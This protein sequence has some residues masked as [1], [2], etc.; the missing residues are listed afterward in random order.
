[1]DL[2]RAAQLF[3]LRDLR[4]ALLGIFVVGGGLTL[5][6]LTLYAQQ[7]GHVPLIVVAAS[8]SLGFVL[9]ILLF[10]VPPLAR[11]AGR[12][13]SQMNL[14]FEFAAG[15]A[16]AIGLL[17]IVGFSA[18]STGNNLLFLVLAF[19]LASLL[20]AFTAGSICL[21]RLDVTMRF[22]ETIF[23]EEKTPILV[24]MHNRKRIFPAFSV[25][26]EVRGKERERSIAAEHMDAVFPRW[27][28][29]RL[30]QAPVIRRTLSHFVYT[31]ARSFAEN[32]ADHRF[33][34]R[35]KLAI[36]DFEL[37]TRFPFGFFRHR[38]RLPAREAELIVFPKLVEVS[39]LLD[40]IALDAGRRVAAKKGSGHDL[41]ALRDYLPE[42][43]LRRVDWKATARTRRLTVRE[44]AADDER[45]VAV[46]LDL[47]VSDDGEP[48]VREK[49]ASEQRGESVVVS[50]RF[51]A[52]ASIACSLL[53]SLA[54]ERSELRLVVGDVDTGFGSGR[55][56]LHE[57]LKQISLASPEPYLDQLSEPS[58]NLERILD[59][60]GDS[61]CLFVTSSGVDGLSPELLQKLKIIGF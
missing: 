11:N 53:M 2:K 48:P 26:V 36:K 33:P 24:T 58:A 60:L 28:A 20:V 61:H 10:I 17:L 50:K 12:E 6:G 27:I 31:R 56:H 3:S 46:I 44:F 16:V 9:L 19:L 45:R 59:R 23:A 55:A 29:R 8:A 49:V 21:R 37:S 1:M 51:E 35:G 25:V 15:G 18:W 52:G 5:S 22:P 40:T 32:R 34:H 39:A 14:P 7:I 47:R 43:D 42:D 30:G 13:A 38:R 54:A 41:L 4:N 57:M